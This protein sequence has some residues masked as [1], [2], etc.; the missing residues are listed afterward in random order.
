[1]PKSPGIESLRLSWINDKVKL[2]FSWFFI[3]FK[4]VDWV[5]K[6]TSELTT[7]TYL[8]FKFFKERDNASPVPFGLFW[9]TYA[10][11]LSILFIFDL[12]FSYSELTTAILLLK[13]F[14]GKFNN[15]YSMSVIPFKRCIG[16]LK[17]PDCILEPLPAANTTISN[18]FKK[19]FIS[20]IIYN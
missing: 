6:G 10:N 17:V 4:Y 18:V 19:E 13:F 3:K 11:S 8:D 9:T 12:I 1:M 15:K 2:L 5:I 7:T 14:K 20:I 16:I